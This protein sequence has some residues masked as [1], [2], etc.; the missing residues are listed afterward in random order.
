MHAVSGIDLQPFAT[1]TVIDHL[2]DAGGTE[3]L[4]GVPILLRALGGQ[5]CVCVAV[6]GQNGSGNV[7]IVA[8]PGS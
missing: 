7:E 2:V 4:A 3:A 6:E 8:S 1:V 5:P